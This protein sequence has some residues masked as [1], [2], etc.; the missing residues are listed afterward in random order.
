MSM[1]TYVRAGLLSVGGGGI[2]YTAANK[3]NRSVC[4]MVV[5]TVN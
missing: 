4:F 1:V 5:L 3:R 2:A